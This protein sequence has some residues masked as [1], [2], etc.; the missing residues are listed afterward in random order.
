VTA[1]YPDLWGEGDSSEATVQVNS[2]L[3]CNTVWHRIGWHVSRSLERAPRLECGLVSG[4]SVT[5]GAKSC[6]TSFWDHRTSLM[7]SHRGV[8]FPRLEKW[9]DW[10]GA[11]TQD[12][13]TEPHISPWAVFL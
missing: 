2:D 4:M 11:G 1:K 10:E 13:C 7:G 3:C 9:V 8:C 5:R 12:L 6:G